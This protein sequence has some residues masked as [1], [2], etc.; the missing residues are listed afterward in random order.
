MALDP[1]VIKQIKTLAAL[2]PEQIDGKLREWSEQDP[3]K[4][5]QAINGLVLTMWVKIMS[6]QNASQ[7]AVGAVK[8]LQQLLESLAQGGAPGAEVA[9]APVV[10]PTM[11]APAAGGPRI[12]GDGAPITDPVQ[13]AAEQLMDQAAGP[14]P[15]AAP[16]PQPQ[17]QPRGRARRGSGGPPNPSHLVG[18]DGQPND[19][20]QIEAESI[21][22]AAAG[23]R[24]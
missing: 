17:G 18:A 5:C 6:A 10:P 3:A 16:A 23:P 21:L 1:A 14:R 12:G 13:L 15:G 19:P 2:S 9:Q 11:A 8:Q 22:D 7:A 4:W 24:Q 20:A